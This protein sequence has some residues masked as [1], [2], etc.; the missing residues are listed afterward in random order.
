MKGPQSLI[1]NSAYKMPAQH[2]GEQLILFNRID[3][4]IILVVYGY[5]NN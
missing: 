5:E 1:I 2:W 3:Y 4:Y